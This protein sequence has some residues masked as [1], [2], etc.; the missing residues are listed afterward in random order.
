MDTVSP[1]QVQEIAEEAY[2]YGLQQVIYFGQRWNNTQNDAKD[3][4]TYAGVNR[5]SFVRKKITPDFPVVTPNSTTLYGT[6]NIDLTSEPVVIEH[7]A[8]TDRYFSLQIMDQYGIFFMMVGNQFNG[9]K[10][11]SYLVVPP[12]YTGKLP[13]GFVTTDVIKAPS[14]TVW[15]GSRI[16]VMTGTDAE[17]KEINEIQDKITITPLSKWIANGRKG[18]PWQGAE[19]VKG[20]YPTYPKM[21]SI[22][23]GQVDKQSAE[24]FF[25]ILNIVLNDPS[26]TLMAD[27]KKE[28]DML[29]RLA[30]IGIGE[31]KD[32]DWTQLDKAT[33]DAL[34]TGFKNEYK[35]VKE[36]FKNNL[37]NMN[38]WMA[39][40]NDGGFETDW[41]SRA[42]MA[43]AGW[44]G[45]DKNVS[46][47]GAFLFV[48][49]EGKP[50]DGQNK[51]TITF[52]MNDLPPVSQFWSIPVYN[53]DGYFVANAIDRYTVN[54]FMI[55][56]KQLH[57]ADGK[58]VVYL[59]KDKP[60][61]PNQLKNWL[62]APPGNFRFTSRFYG[63]D[64]SLTDGSYKM[65]RPV[66]VK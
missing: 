33:Q 52:D 31:G 27:S 11:R 45:P 19:R 36:T 54:S 16:A 55:D 18:V 14:K 49:A 62:P 12:N 20:D 6:G 65:P 35:K 43:D 48:D 4:P 21:K 44:A 41:M 1:K 22:V 25:T 58:L 5:L 66:K 60:T 10:A 39:L 8:V 47:T 7:P 28:D 51:Y 40:R 63:P 64:I 57:I 53:K 56:Q 59:Q 13:A 42:V 2:L 34:T 17:I 37:I 50:L 15:G 9:T 46:H 3:H 32:F 26:M 30:S 38:G 24:D 23:T 61:D 29:A